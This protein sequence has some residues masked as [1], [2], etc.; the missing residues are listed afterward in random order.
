MGEG[1]G[2]LVEQDYHFRFD[3]VAD[4]TL[5]V[6]AARMEPGADSSGMPT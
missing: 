3:E 1:A 5:F 6:Y 4:V 2:A